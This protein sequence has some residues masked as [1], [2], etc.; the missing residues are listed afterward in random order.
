MKIAGLKDMAYWET[1]PPDAS[2]HTITSLKPGKRRTLTFLN[3]RRRLAGELVLRGDETVPQKVTLKPWGTLT[4][5]VVRADGEPWARPRFTHSFC[6]TVIPRSEKM[7][8]FAS[9]AWF[10]ESC[11]RFISC[12]NS[13]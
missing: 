3:E 13:A 5:R 9:K 8:G 1:P 2:T 12:L 11:T 6:P 10:P 7:A 4:G